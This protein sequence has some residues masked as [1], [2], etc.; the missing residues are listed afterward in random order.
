[1]SRLFVVVLWVSL[2]GGAVAAEP[3]AAGALRPEHPELQ[4]M[5]DRGVRLSPTFGRLATELEGT[6]LAVYVRY[7]RCARA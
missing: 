4:E 2:F 3:R 1:M 7:A 5:I 6:S